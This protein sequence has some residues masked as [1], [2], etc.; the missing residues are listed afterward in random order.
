MAAHLGVFSLP[1]RHHLYGQLGSSAGRYQRLQAAEESLKIGC[2]GQAKNKFFSDNFR[3]GCQKNAVVKSLVFCQ[4]GGGGH[5]E[6]N[7][8]LVSFP[9]AIVKAFNVM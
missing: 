7:L 8:H 3:E 4:A 1:L 9:N 2:A 5:S 6:P